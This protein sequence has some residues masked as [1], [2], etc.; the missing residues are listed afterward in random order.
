[1]LKIRSQEGVLSELVAMRRLANEMGEN[2]SIFDSIFKNK[3]ENM[4]ERLHRHIDAMA[5]SLGV[6]LPPR[7]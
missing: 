2:Q 7:F 4:S 6:Q 5:Y 1:M 3:D